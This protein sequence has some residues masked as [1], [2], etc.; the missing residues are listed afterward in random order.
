[1]CNTP[2]VCFPGAT[3]TRGLVSLRILKCVATF[4]LI[5]NLFLL[6]EYLHLKII[7]DLI[8]IGNKN[9]EIDLAAPWIAR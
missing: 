2:E 9:L 5:A 8:R 3:S 1:M 6:G 4:S 7:L